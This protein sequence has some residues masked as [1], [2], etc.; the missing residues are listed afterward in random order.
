MTEN[1]MRSL[2]LPKG[3][4]ETLERL[5]SSD[6]T[7]VDRL[8]TE[9]LRESIAILEADFPALKEPFRFFLKE[10]DDFF[11]SYAIYPKAVRPVV[12]PYDLELRVRQI[13][14][15]QGRQ[16]GDLFS[17]LV[18]NGLTRALLRK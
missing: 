8:V 12:I 15:G 3:R 5:A 11:C 2:R 14:F 6:S 9:L 10:P 4:M 17:D 16:S 1:R 13:A 7:T 18:D